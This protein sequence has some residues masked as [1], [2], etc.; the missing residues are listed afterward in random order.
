[1]IVAARIVRKILDVDA[2]PDFG[3]EMAHGVHTAQRSVQRSRVTN[4]THDKAA[5]PGRVP[6]VDVCPQRVKRPNFM[7]TCGQLG[8]DMLADETRR[9]GEQHKH[10]ARL[11]ARTR[12]T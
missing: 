7:P 10:D 12:S 6:T 9:T 4:V 2:E 3:R 5:D 11:P 1:V 8:M